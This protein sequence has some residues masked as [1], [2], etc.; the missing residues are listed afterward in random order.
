M[1]VASTSNMLPDYPVSIAPL[2]FKHPTARPAPLHRPFNAPHP[3]V[4]PHQS[5]EEAVRASF[6]PPLGAMASFTAKHK[7]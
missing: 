6:H 5:V 3:V 4:S 1:G 2:H 7:S